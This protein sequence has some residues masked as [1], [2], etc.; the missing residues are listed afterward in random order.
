M[1]F[2]KEI[3]SLN[4]IVLNSNIRQKVANFKMGWIGFVQTHFIIMLILHIFKNNKMVN[5]K[6]ILIKMDKILK[7]KLKWN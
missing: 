6:N 4:K 5:M 2:G 3:S 7:W 1:E